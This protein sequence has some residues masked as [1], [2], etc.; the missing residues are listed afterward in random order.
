ME[1]NSTRNWIIENTL[2][3]QNRFG[4]DHNLTVLLGQSAQRNRYYFLTGTPRNVPNNSEGDLY[5]TLGSNDTSN[6]RNVS[7]G[8]TLTTAA[9]YF[10]RANYSFRNRYLLNASLR[11]DAASQFYGGGNLWGYFPSVG[12]GWVISNEDFMS[13]QDVFSNLKLRGS[14][15]KIG[16]AIVPINPTTLTVTQSPALTAIFGGNAYTGASINSVVPPFLN[17]ERGNGL[18]IGLE[19]GLLNGRLSL[20]ADWYRR[21]TEQAI[22]AIPILNSVGTGSSSIVGNQ[23]SIKNSGFEL[24]ATW[25]TEV[26]DNFR[27]TV[28]GNIGINDNKVLSVVTGANP[29]YAGGGGLTSGALSTRTVVGQPIG[30]FFG[31]QVAGIFQTAAEVA[32]SP[33]KTAKPGDFRYVDQNGD[34]AITDRDRVVLGN[35]NAKYTFGLNTAFNYANFDFALD[36][37]GVAGVDVY[38]ANL[39]YRFGNENFSKD[40]YENRWRGP[41]TST[42][43]PSA[44]I[45][46]GNNYMPNSFFV[47]SGSYVRVR[48]IQLGY[49]LPQAL[50]AKASLQ[51]VRVFANAQ[52]PLNFF[53]Y[54]GFSP[55]IGGTPTNAGIDANVYPL[56]ATYNFGINV[57]F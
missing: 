6:P 4:D 8:G 54:R 27:Y 15:G 25:N 41:G 57:T 45:G 28:S 31:Y 39:A 12:A 29:I 42:T 48:N 14:W 32:G 40:F 50:S 53:K 51:R 33:Q 34:G 5:L 46:G 22:F 52:N 17:W 23:A 47:E 9:S 30:Q 49:T 20:E 36:L 55:E 35:P 10:T 11:A 18:D 19:A 7:D 44:N 1:R 56:Y 38:N 26:S 21:V 37:Q 16:N 3:Y 13:E 43:Y 24:V 2:T